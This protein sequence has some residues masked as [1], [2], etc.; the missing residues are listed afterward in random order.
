MKLNFLIPLILLS[1]ASFVYA[2][3]EHVDHGVTLSQSNGVFNNQG[4]QISISQGTQVSI[5]YEGEGIARV[6]IKSKACTLNILGS[7][8]GSQITSFRNPNNQEILIVF[9]ERGYILMYPLQG[10]D[11]FAKASCSQLPTVLGRFNRVSKRKSRSRTQN[12]NKSGTSHCKKEQSHEIS[13]HTYEVS[14]KWFKSKLEDTRQIYKEM[15]VIPHYKRG[16]QIGFKL[17]G[18]RKRAF[19]KCLGLKQ[20]DV[21]LS[22]EGQRLDSMQAALLFHEK[23]KF[24]DHVYLELKRRKKLIRLDYHIK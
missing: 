21:L 1:L 18:F 14:K 16:K 11:T 24:D 5:R 10:F 17:V 20:G 9:Y 15:R 2:E 3:D 6:K 23:F 8:L 19:V 4:T 12:K 13:P 7:T 22:I